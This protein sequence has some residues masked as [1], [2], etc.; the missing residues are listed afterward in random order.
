MVLQV[1][2]RIPEHELWCNNSHSETLLF[3]NLW[4]SASQLTNFEVLNSNLH[5]VM[6]CYLLSVFFTTIG[7]VSVPS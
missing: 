7:M 3:L 4:H 6:S 1:P 5:A 2:H